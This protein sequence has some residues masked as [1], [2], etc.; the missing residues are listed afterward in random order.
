MVIQYYD[1]I[2]N[3]K[4]PDKKYKLTKVISNKEQ[5]EEFYVSYDDSNEIEELKNK[6]EDLTTSLTISQEAL[7][8][9]ILSNIE[10]EKQ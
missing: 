9:L 6:V 4:E 8:D 7:D 10:S 2:F 1:G 3:G 5:C